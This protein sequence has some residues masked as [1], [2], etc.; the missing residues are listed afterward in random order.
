VNPYINDCD[1]KKNDFLALSDK[2][3]KE[4]VTKKCISFKLLLDDL[5]TF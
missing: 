5:N 2:Q 1:S 3:N 4:Y